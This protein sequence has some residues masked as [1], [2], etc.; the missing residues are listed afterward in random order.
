MNPTSK[1]PGRAES[2]TMAFANVKQPKLAEVVAG[3][4]RD[5]I[6][7]GSLEVGSRLPPEREL[8]DQFGVSR[9]TMREALTLLESQGFIEMRTGRNGGAYVTKPDLHHLASSFDVLLRVQRTP[10]NSLLEAREHLEPLAASL[11]CREA[12]DEDLQKIEES[13]TSMRA[14]LE[15]GD[16]ARYKHETVQFH[17]LVA[18]ASHNELIH[19]FTVIT[20][21]LVFSKAYDYLSIDDE[22]NLRAHERILEAL[23]LGNA[24]GASRRMRRH[25]EAFE[26][27]LESV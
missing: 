8:I 16:E 7:T 5:E 10:I 15:R 23:K 19:A 9:G 12:T 4:V 6:A 21:E 14:A 22:L 3:H 24:E 1:E 11:A 27:L 25:V 13:V 18:E 20:Q 26:T 2:S 17:V